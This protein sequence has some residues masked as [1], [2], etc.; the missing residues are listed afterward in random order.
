MVL[1]NINR[2]EFKKLVLV[3]HVPQLLKTPTIV[4]IIFHLLRRS[5]GNVYTKA[6]NE[7]QK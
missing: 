6:I 3:L 5:V 4:N 2:S 7:R 1:V